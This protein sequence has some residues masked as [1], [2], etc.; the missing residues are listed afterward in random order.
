MDIK[1]DKNLLKELNI[2]TLYLF[3]SQASGVFDKSSDVDVAVLF[4][5]NL[6][7]MTTFEKTVLLEQSLR[8]LNPFLFDIVPL[9]SAPGI[10]K[11]EVIS[12]C[13]ILYCTDNNCRI[14]FEVKSIKE[15]IDEQ[16]YRNIYNNS[17]SERILE[18][19]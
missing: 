1:I 19:V 17:L 13:K 16:F 12:N 3:G 8:E 4:S 11:Y 2:N 7:P 14:D 5:K 10:L 9:N 6:D 15:Y 18:R